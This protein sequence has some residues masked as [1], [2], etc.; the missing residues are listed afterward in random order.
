M[1]A[2]DVTVAANMDV[3]TFTHFAHAADGLGLVFAPLHLAIDRGY[4]T[5][6][7][8]ELRLDAPPAPPYGW[9]RVAAQASD[10]GAGYFSFAASE[11]A[12]GAMVVALVH[13]ENRRGHGFTHLV[14]RNGLVASGRLR[15]PATLRGLRIGLLPDRGDDYMAYHWLLETG[16]LTLGSDVFPVPVP[17]AGAE[18]YRALERDEVDVL[19]ARRP[20]DV[21]DDVRE[22]WVERWRFGYDVHPDLQAQFLVFS[23]TFANERPD[24]A[25]R[26][27]AAYLRGARAYA[28]AFER[29]IGR[30]A[31]INDLVRITGETR[32]VIAQMSP[33][34]F[35]PNGRIDR[36]RLERDRAILVERGLFP[37]EVSLDDIVDDRFADRALARIGRYDEPLLQVR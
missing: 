27:T 18:R 2:H 8:I 34:Y 30:D 14:A 20:R 10:V 7:G 24:V 16:G 33:V 19:I 15:E 28:D 6:E 17:H 22:G 5:A 4:F 36:T 25:T 21:A 23:R 11:R 12:R 32:A 37:A 31:M 26:F 35:A 13:E 29:G 9:L 3:V 1:R